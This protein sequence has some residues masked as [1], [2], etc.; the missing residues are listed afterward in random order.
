MKD[1][2]FEHLTVYKF[3][4]FGVWRER[5]LASLMSGFMA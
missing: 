3:A 1:E 4:F 5:G 2:G